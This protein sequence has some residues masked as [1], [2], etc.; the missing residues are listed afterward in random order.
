MIVDWFHVTLFCFYKDAAN[1]NKRSN[2]SANGYKQLKF[3][4]ILEGYK[5]QKQPKVSIPTLPVVP[6]SV[7]HFDAKSCS[8]AGSEF[9][10]D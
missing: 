10:T 3:D 8:D 2:Q 5:I 9:D 6:K 7:I 1:I 4:P